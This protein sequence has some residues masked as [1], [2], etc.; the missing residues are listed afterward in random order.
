[1]E[2]PACVN[3]SG[4]TQDY[5]ELM[6]YVCIGAACTYG[7]VWMSPL[8]ALPQGMKCLSED[9]LVRDAVQTEQSV[10]KVYF[11]EV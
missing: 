9:C 3:L 7:G 10:F 6:L 2:K 5:E 4:F 11:A 8:E 1:M